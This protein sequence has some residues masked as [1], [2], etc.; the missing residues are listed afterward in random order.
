M[1][2][3]T[4]VTAIIKIE[5]NKYNSDYVDWISNLLL[6]VNKN[7]VIFT[8]IEYY[9]LLQSLRK[10]YETKTFIIVITIDEFY[11]YKNHLDYLKKDHN[12]DF[13]K[14]IHNVDLYM[15]WNEKLK[16]IERT[17]N[18]NPFKTENF[19]WCDIGYVRN[20]LYADL[21][22]KN[23][24][25]MK[26]ITEDKIYMLNI[27]YNFT[28]D[29]YKFPFDN[30]YRNISNIIGGGFIIGNEKNLRK[31]IDIYYNEIMPF[32]IKNDLFIGKDQTLYVSMYLKYPQLFKLIRGEND[33][34]TIQFSELKWFYFLKYL[35]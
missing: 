6:N 17:M 1:D 28:E 5:K 19:A 3:I 23:F 7:M 34:T 13:E 29:D 21:Y 25:N 15:I 16:L 24:P 32:Y 31:M 22:V 27:D 2:D 33:N 8:T 14:N 20:K 35:S 10:N 9:E 12:R 30:K 4:L 18:I 26:K 11:M